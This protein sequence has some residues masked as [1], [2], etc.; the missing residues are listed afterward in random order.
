MIKSVDKSDLKTLQRIARETF[1]ESFGDQNT[2]E[3]INLYLEEGLS[4]KSLKQ[5]INNP[6][7]DFYFLYY[8]SQLAGYLKLNQGLAQTDSKL[9]NALE[10]ERIYIKSE[11]QGEGLGGRLLRYSLSE[12][13]DRGLDW[14]WLGVW[15]NNQKAIAFY[16]HY[17]FQVFDQHNFRLGN[18]LQRDYLMKI[19]IT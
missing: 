6:D 12:A 10:I 5:Q 1:L 15:E 9:E 7:T 16:T 3:N 8:N 4:L 19:K 18:E 2:E 14:L 11:Y 17:G 13:K